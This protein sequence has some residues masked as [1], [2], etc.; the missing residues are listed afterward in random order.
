MIK[1]L[2]PNNDLRTE[3]GVITKWGCLV[4][5]ISIVFGIICFLIGRA[6]YG[7]CVHKS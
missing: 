1:L 3:D 4:A 6:I 7:K 2:G 5:L